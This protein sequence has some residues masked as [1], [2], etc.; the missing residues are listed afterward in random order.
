MAVKLD[1]A[2][3]AVPCGD[4]DRFAGI[5]LTAANEGFATVVIGGCLTAA[6]SGEGMTC[7]YLNLVADGTGGVKKAAGAEGSDCLVVAVEDGMATF[8]M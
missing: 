5:A 2:G 6:A 1:T 8:M 3:K 4:N 7:G